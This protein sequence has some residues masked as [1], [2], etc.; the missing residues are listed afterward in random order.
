LKFT[1]LLFS[2]AGPSTTEINATRERSSFPGVESR[3]P[4]KLCEPGRNQHKR[5]T[6][7]ISDGEEETESRDIPSVT[8]FLLIA[9]DFLLQ[10]T[11]AHLLIIRERE[12]ANLIREGAH[13][14]A[15]NSTQRSRG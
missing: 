8:I 3:T 12:E 9:S 14:T 13:P 7:A 10:N 4:H 11:Y 5:I 15:N 1:V 6:R 2:R